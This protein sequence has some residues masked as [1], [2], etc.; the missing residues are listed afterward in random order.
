MPMDNRERDEVLKTLQF[1]REECTMS[2]YIAPISQDYTEVFRIH[3]KISPSPSSLVHNSSLLK[4]GVYAQRK[5]TRKVTG[6]KKTK[7]PVLLTHGQA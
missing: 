1:S 7:W 5:D 6:R 2:L 3:I 4:S